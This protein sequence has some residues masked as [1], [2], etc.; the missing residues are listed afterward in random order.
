MS[1]EWKVAQLRDEDVING[2]PG[3]NRCCA[4]ALCLERLEC[5]SN[6]KRTDW[7]PEVHSSDEIYINQGP[8]EEKQDYRWID[9]HK[10]DRA[11]LDEWIQAFDEENM[12]GSSPRDDEDYIGYEATYQMLLENPI[13]FRYRVEK[14]DYNDWAGRDK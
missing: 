3:S 2:A 1:K 8:Y 5:E 6:P 12:D 10:E 7:Y 9:V 4:V 11:D 14:G 13:R